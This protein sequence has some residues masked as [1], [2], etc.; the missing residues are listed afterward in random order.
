MELGDKGKT[1][2]PNDVRVLS[3]GSDQKGLV[4]PGDFVRPQATGAGV[5]V[6][7]GTIDDRL[8]APHIGFPSPVASSMRVG[9]LNSKSDT[10]SA[11]IAF[12]HVLHLLLGIK[13]RSTAISYQVC[14]RKAR[15]SGQKMQRNFE[16]IPPPG[17]QGL[18]FPAGTDIMTGK[19]TTGDG[20]GNADGA[21]GS[22]PL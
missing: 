21:L 15:G 13:S 1:R 11:D 5:D 22:A 14:G 12:C 7:R 10:F 4:C 16:F 18:Y 19:K 20:P 17:G 8:D 2:T 6:A 9:N 3:V